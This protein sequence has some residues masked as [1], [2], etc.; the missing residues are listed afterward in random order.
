MPEELIATRSLEAKERGGCSK[1]NGAKEL[2]MHRIDVH[3]CTGFRFT[4]LIFAQPI[5]AQCIPTIRR[6]Y[7]NTHSERD[8]TLC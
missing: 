6:G 1:I 4:H 2:K 5:V 8:A 7:I 3:I